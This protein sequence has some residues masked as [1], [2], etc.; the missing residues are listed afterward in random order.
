MVLLGP[1]ES[2]LLLLR[3][4]AHSSPVL[5]LTRNFNFGLLTKILCCA[6][7]TMKQNEA[8][9]NLPLRKCQAVGVFKC[10]V[11]FP[12]LSASHAFYIVLFFSLSIVK[13]AH[14]SP[15]LFLPQHSLSIIFSCRLFFCFLLSSMFKTVAL[16]LLVC[17]YK[18]NKAK[19]LILSRFL[20]QCIT[21]NLV[22]VS[23]LSEKKKNKI[24]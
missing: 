6:L 12:L 4:S 7:C 21:P 1:R 23:F 15:L 18:L 24:K 11:F 19:M 20:S 22:V 13:L 14:K 17:L 16:L 8:K 10:V 3:S 5:V 9:A 2:P